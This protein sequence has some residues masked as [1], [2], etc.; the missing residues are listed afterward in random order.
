MGA[1]NGHPKLGSSLTI[2]PMKMMV[3]SG[4]MLKITLRNL[5]RHL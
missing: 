4:W 3:Y 5:V 1:K 2:T